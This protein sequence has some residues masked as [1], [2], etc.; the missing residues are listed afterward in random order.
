VGSQFIYSCIKANPN[1]QYFSYC[2]V[3]VIVLNTIWE[4][5]AL[6]SYSMHLNTIIQCM[7]TAVILIYVCVCES[8]HLGRM[9]LWESVQGNLVLAQLGCGV[10]VRVHLGRVQLRE[11]VLVR[12]HKAYTVHTHR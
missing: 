2:T 10:C 3:A 12:A 8:C 9:H 7:T 11:S 5:A 6:F 1:P 4:G